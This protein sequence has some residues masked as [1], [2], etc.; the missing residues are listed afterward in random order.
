MATTDSS[1]VCIFGEKSIDRKK[2]VLITFNTKLEEKVVTEVDYRV[3]FAFGCV[4][5]KYAFF[6]NGP[7][8]IMKV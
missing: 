2:C 7:G 5:G 4:N 1:T 8:C 3:G 6:S